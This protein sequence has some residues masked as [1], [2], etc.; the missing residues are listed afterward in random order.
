[1]E[2]LRK[3]LE[4]H[5]RDSLREQHIDFTIDAMP[6]LWDIKYW[7]LPKLQEQVTEQHDSIQ[8]DI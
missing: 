7:E 4:K 8:D 2:V 1:M 3:D 6:T 5:K